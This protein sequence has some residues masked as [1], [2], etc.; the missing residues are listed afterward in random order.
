MRLC[1]VGVLGASFVLAAA[2]L[3]PLAVAQTVDKPVAVVSVAPLDR[4]L[5]DVAYLLRATNFPEIGGVVRVMA[6]QYTQGI[7][8][9]RPW[10]VTIGLDGEMP[11][12]MLFLPMADRDAFFDALGSMGIEPDDLG[13]GLF[14]IDTNGQMLYA[15]DAGGWLF[16]AQDES[17]LANVPS[18]PAAALGELPNKYDLAIRANIQALPEELKGMAT[19]QIR[20]GFERTL[21]EQSE[22]EQAAAREVGEAQLAQIEQLMNE[23]E[24]VIFGWAIEPKA[25]KTY[26]DTAAQFVE[27]TRLAS[28]MDAVQ[29]LTSDFTAFK[30][31]NS[32]ASFRAT[33]EL[34]EET[35]KAVMKQSIDNSMAQAATQL[36]E[37]G[38]D[39][40]AREMID[41]LVAAMTEILYK[42]IDEGKFD[43]AGSLSVADDTL[44]ILVGGRLAD[45]RALEQELKDLIKG[46][47]SGDSTPVAEFDYEVFS[48][49]TLHRL[50]VPV[51]IP[52]PAARKVFGDELKFVIG[53]FDK[54]FMVA[55]DATGDAALKAAITSMQAASNKA[56]QPLEGVVEVGSILKFAQSVSPNSM[57]DLTIDTVD[58]FAGKDKLQ[59]A[60]SVIP[61]GMIYR[62]T[63][64]EGVLRAVGTAA[65][66]GGAGGGGF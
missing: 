14:E 42:T 21:A 62:F 17:L 29:N 63:I 7:D 50:S 19:E 22:E 3:Q 33:S 34:T 9:S 20:L 6:D 44:R 11:T 2:G 16:V 13:D 53:T 48:G 35:D 27:G 47:P 39:G 37:Q 41:K 30:L 5:Q 38:V 28:Q 52:D 56:A 15:K 4:L 64:E 58:Q 61:R 65:K 40:E 60:A 8:K 57:L 54:G 10:G 31:A 49:V 12:G 46:L 36:D 43:G 25:Q 1:R 23:T 26:L 51:K 55:M 32:S 59:V 18:D 45:G 24:Q 66:S